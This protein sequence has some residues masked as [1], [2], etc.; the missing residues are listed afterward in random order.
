MKPA[1]W[2]SLIGIVVAVIAAVISTFVLLQM[3]Q[4]TTIARRDSELKI[5]PVLFIK[6]LSVNLK[7][8]KVESVDAIVI[9][10]GL[11]PALNVR[12]QIGE[13]IRLPGSGVVLK[14][15]MFE[16]SQIIQ[17]LPNANSATGNTNVSITMRDAST[18]SMTGGISGLAENA[19]Q[20]SSILRI[21]LA[22]RPDG[23]A[24]L[25]LHSL[26]LT[27]E[28]L[29]GALKDALFITKATSMTN[30]PVAYKNRPKRSDTLEEVN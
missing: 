30:A 21:F 10:S 15:E 29:E 3:K 16:E 9:N 8:D 14:P 28:E 25:R 19:L 4:D 6:D 23:Q 17:V 11:G 18:L 12:T 24:Q 5:R 13:D 1:D 2:I 27:K 20:S 7:D 26:G 22:K